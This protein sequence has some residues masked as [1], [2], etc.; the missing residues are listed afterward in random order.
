MDPS[1][2]VSDN[3]AEDYMV[4][5]DDTAQALQKSGQSVS[6]SSNMGLFD[7]DVTDDT[8]VFDLSQEVSHF[9]ISSLVGKLIHLC[10]I[11]PIAFS[12]RKWM[13][14]RT[15]SRILLTLLL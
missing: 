9:V 10:F 3:V 14:S 12:S 11:R 13:L 1:F 8:G 2:Y 6:V 7:T 15:L 4:W 5:A